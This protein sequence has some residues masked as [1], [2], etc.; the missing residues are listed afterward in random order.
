[1]HRIKVPT[2][3]KIGG[4]DY[5]IKQSARINRELDSA[6]V[7][8]KHM[9]PLRE[10]Q[11]ESDGNIDA[12]QYSQTFLHEL[13]HAISSVY[14]ENRELAEADVAAVSQGLYQVLEQLGVRFVK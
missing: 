14:C 3:I 8:G 2:K 9:S 12:Q 13:A 11:L 1:M 5:T 4:F 10:I 6:G 7:W